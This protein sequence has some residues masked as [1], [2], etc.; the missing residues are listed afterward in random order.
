MTRK[1]KAASGARGKPSPGRK[2]TSST[3][4]KSNFRDY[5]TVQ[6]TPH[7]SLLEE[8][9]STGHRRT[10]WT[11]ETKLR[12]SKVN[13]VT[14]GLH[15]PTEED[16][17]NQNGQVV[18]RGAEADMEH[19]SGR[20]ERA[21]AFA[22]QALPPNSQTPDLALSD[23]LFVVDIQG[24][25]P[26]IKQRPAPLVRSPS[27]TGS[28]S[29]DE[30]VVFAG[31]R[32]QTSHVPVRV[33]SQASSTQPSAPYLP[34]RII[35]DPVLVEAPRP[36][37]PRLRPS[38]VTQ[39]SR[40]SRLSSNAIAARGSSKPS[41]D[42]VTTDSRPSWDDT[43]VEWSHRSKPGVG[44][45]VPRLK[46]KMTSNPARRG[47]VLPTA[48]E[49]SEEEDEEEQI[50]RDYI[51][52]MQTDDVASP[53][54]MAFLEYRELDVQMA[55]SSINTASKS[56][57]V[58]ASGLDDLDTSEDDEGNR[59]NLSKGKVPMTNGSDSEVDSSDDVVDDED[60]E[61]DDSILDNVDLEQRFQDGIDDEVL[62]RLL[63][64]QEE[65]GIDTEELVLLD[66]EAINPFNIQEEAKLY[67]KNSA[68]KAR[69][70]NGSFPSA[71]LM[72]D[73][74]EQDP[75]G[76]FDIM[77]FGRPSL[78]TKN[79]GKRAQLSVDL[80]DSDLQEALESSWQNDREKKRARKAER[81]IL[82]LQGLLGKKRKGGK[83]KLSD[84]YQEGMNVGD[85]VEVFSNFLESRDQELALPPMD[86][87]RRKMVHELAAAFD[88]NSK[89]KGTKQNRFTL[90]IKT[91]RTRKWDSALFHSRAKQINA[92]Y[93]PRLDAQSRNK[94]PGSRAFRRSAGGG[95]NAPGTKYR[96]GDIV[97]AAAPELGAENRGHAMLM[98]LGWAKGDALGA[99]DNKGI[100][101]PIPHI[102]KNSKAGLG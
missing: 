88:M 48:E 46:P 87:I 79:K 82:R 73:V 90:L 6:D 30:E 18:D 47:Y 99:V 83:A 80:S 32:P 15:I 60:D 98:K 16:N 59:I 22:P 10:D 40:S 20:S 26:A 42:A 31:R 65:L 101:Q 56:T 9:R 34:A 93:F 33:P 53:Q 55:N 43:S 51:E 41:S 74:L 8:A 5:S 94:T 44:W 17:E 45:T 2:S 85:L 58:E 72:A 49:S 7:F 89:S 23:N 68:K 66:D 84:V 61:D 64:K 11:S 62:A 71:S 21:C 38:S 25:K 35:E 24:Q 70:G 50:M 81:E 28:V 36:S 1:K 97:G 91:T 78:R 13:F 100:L 54:N 37:A 92:G 102:V 57:M 29:S 96:D 69:R 77:D 3:R 86:K 27:P 52:N 76:G 14:G 63:A 75:Y 4:Q 67:V 12:Y 95:T 19:L 39:S